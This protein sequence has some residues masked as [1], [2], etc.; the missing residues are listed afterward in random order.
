MM[1]FFFLREHS[2]AKYITSF[3]KIQDLK[4]NFFKQLERL[5][6]GAGVQP[7]IRAVFTAMCDL[8]GWLWVKS[9]ARGSYLSTLPISKTGISPVALSK[10]L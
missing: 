6:A 2:K 5:L 4:N 3:N 8:T 1:F 7:F 9:F 10:L